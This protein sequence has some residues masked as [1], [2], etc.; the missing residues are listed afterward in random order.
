MPNG[1]ADDTGE[2]VI[3]ND[4]LY[5]VR[6]TPNTQAEAIINQKAPFPRYLKAPWWEKEILISP[7]TPPYCPAC[8]R[9]QR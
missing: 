2:V 4:V 6:W 5:Q 1:S 8:G 7:K 3:D 9:Y